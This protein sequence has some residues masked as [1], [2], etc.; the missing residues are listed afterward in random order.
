LGCASCS[1][2]SWS[3]WASAGQHGAR[4]GGK[5]DKSNTHGNI[6]F[7][8]EMRFREARRTSRS[9]RLRSTVMVTGWSV[10][11]FQYQPCVP[12]KG[13]RTCPMRQPSCLSHSS[14]SRRSQRL[15]AR[16]SSKRTSAPSVAQR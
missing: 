1:S 9:R 15:P 7:R 14:Y 2:S 3:G 16:R 10:R 12:S 8:L 5:S 6:L 11:F 4:E 13:A